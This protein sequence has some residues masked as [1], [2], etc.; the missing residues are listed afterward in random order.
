MY[1]MLVSPTS[2][3]LLHFLLPAFVHGCG[4]SS[5]VLR[6]LPVSAYLKCA[7]MP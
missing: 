2:I 5:P 7:C 3:E 1:Y 4:I 6:G